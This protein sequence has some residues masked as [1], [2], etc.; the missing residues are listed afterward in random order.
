M[1]QPTERTESSSKVTLEEVLRLKRAERPSPEFWARFEQDLRAKQ[2]A[3]IVEPCPWWI[4]W[5]LPAL[6][7][8]FARFQ[9]PIAA[10]AVI[11]LG[12]MVV[13]EYQSAVT[14]ESVPAQDAPVWASAPA[15]V[16]VVGLVDK[17]TSATDA[18]SAI[19]NDFG[20]AIPV[21]VTE[22]LPDGPGALMAMIPWAAPADTEDMS[23]PAALGEFP[24][25]SFVAAIKPAREQHFDGRVEVE[26]AIAVTA[27][28]VAQ[29]SPVSPREIRRNR[30]LSTLVVAD[31]ASDSDRSRLAN[32]RDVVTSSLASDQLYDSARRLGMG[33]DRLTLKF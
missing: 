24:P 6:V 20:T 3:A 27:S 28:Q 23:A 4:V 26:S 12:F 16:S 7:R 25:V 14:A 9:V 19:G 30:I 29:V 22:P 31:N 18:V 11:V 10:T 15:E 2:L 8:T 5:R 33:G 1:M 21:V 32:P 17:N 13:S